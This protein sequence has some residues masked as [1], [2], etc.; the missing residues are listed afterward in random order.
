MAPR[1]FAHHSFSLAEICNK[2]TGMGAL[3]L[4]LRATSRLQ[5]RSQLRCFRPHFMS[6]GGKVYPIIVVS[7]TVILILGSTIVII[8]IIPWM[9][10][11]IFLIPPNKL[12]SFP[13]FFHFRYHYYFQGLHPRFPHFFP[14]AVH[15]NHPN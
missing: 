6:R 14:P 15:H 3:P 2:S 5:P 12:P 7:S 4:Q 1:G 9:K 8:I 13:S 11:I 10:M